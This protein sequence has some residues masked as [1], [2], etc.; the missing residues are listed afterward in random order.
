MHG[1]IVGNVR[2]LVPDVD[3]YWELAQ[4]LGVPVILPIE[5]R[6]YGMRDF[7][8]AGPISPNLFVSTSGTDSDYIVKLIDVCPDDTPNERD[9]RTPV[10]EALDYE[11]ELVREIAYRFR[12]AGVLFLDAIDHPLLDLSLKRVAAEPSHFFL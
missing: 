2:V 4:R 7:T 8:I 6:Y 1:Q 5:D 12:H 9:E 10:V 3:R 11:G